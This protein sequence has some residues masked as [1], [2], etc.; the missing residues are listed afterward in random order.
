MLPHLINL[1]QYIGLVL[2]HIGIWNV[3]YSI[4]RDLQG[5][6]G[7]WALTENGK[8]LVSTLGPWGWILWGECFYNDSLDASWRQERPYGLMHSNS[9]K[10]GKLRGKLGVWP[11]RAIF[12]TWH[13]HSAISLEKFTVRAVYITLAPPEGSIWQL[14]KPSSLGPQECGLSQ[15]RRTSGT[16]VKLWISAP[17]EQRLDSSLKGQSP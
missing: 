2:L 4:C 14:L 9:R 12:Q 3:W 10:I 7:R 1:G 6:D 16:E 13:S 5:R 8:F 15:G 17:N 11:G